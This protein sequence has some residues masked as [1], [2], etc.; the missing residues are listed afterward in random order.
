MAVIS[1]FDLIHT[2]LLGTNISLKT[3]WKTIIDGFLNMMIIIISII[4]IVHFNNIKLIKLWAL[5]SLFKLFR[6]MIF[7]FNFDRK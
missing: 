3:H 5:F 1:L 4:L 7:Y 6:Y 2:F